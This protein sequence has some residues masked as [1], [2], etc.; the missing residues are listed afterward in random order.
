MPF[1][2]S[3]II[4]ICTYIYIYVCILYQRRRLRQCHLQRQQLQYWGGQGGGGHTLRGEEGQ[5][6]QEGEGGGGR[7]G[8]GKLL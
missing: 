3:H 6:G 7:Q 5:E 4:Y 1:T 2:E 8:G